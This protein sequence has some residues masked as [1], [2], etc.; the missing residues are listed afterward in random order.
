V[1]VSGFIALVYTYVYIIP[2]KYAA[3]E[4]FP[5]LLSY[6]LLRGNLGGEN[7]ILQSDTVRHFSS[8]SARIQEDGGLLKPLQTQ[9]GMMCED[10]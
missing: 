1:G 3:L 8:G 6:A 10:S 4:G 9:V 5:D 2:Q 7:L